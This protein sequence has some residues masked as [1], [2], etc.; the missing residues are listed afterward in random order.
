M[1]KIRRCQHSEQN[2]VNKSASGVERQR[3]VEQHLVESESQNQGKPDTSLLATSLMKKSAQSSSDTVAGSSLS[4]SDMQQG[5]HELSSQPVVPSWVDI[6]DSSNQK[7]TMISQYQYIAPA[8]QEISVESKRIVDQILEGIL[9]DEIDQVREALSDRHFSEEIFLIGLQRFK[10]IEFSL[11][12]QAV[13]RERFEIL[14][15][16]LCSSYCTEDVLSHQMNKRY[17]TSTLLSYAIE[18]NQ[19]KACELIMNAPCFRAHHYL[20]TKPLLRLKLGHSV[21]DEILHIMNTLLS[22][23]NADAVKQAL[24]MKN[25]EGM[26]PLISVLVE[27]TDFARVDQEGK[28]RFENLLNLFYKMCGLSEHPENFLTA[29]DDSQTFVLGYAVNTGLLEV[30]EALFQLDEFNETLLYIPDHQNKNIF[31]HA[32]CSELIGK[33]LLSIP[34]IE[35]RVFFEV[36]SDYGYTPLHVAVSL[37]EEGLV[38]L[39]LKPGAVENFPEAAIYVPD[40]KGRSIL[41]TAIQT[42]SLTMVELLL[43]SPY[44]DQLLLLKDEDERTPIDYLKYLMTHQEGAFSEDSRVR[45]LSMIARLEKELAKLEKELADAQLAI[46][47]KLEKDSSYQ[48]NPRLKS[49]ESQQRS[50]TSCLA[51]RKSRLAKWEQSKKKSTETMEKIYD[52]LLKFSNI[53][54]DNNAKEE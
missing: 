2:A 53:S 14:D 45:Q 17:D 16:L 27:L 15:L 41:H 23:R 51:N 39:Y 28:R 46:N 31:F 30:M 37:K 35:S 25:E 52:L 4:M 50:S 42:E 12:E 38:K 26:T 20:E 3:Q 44:K 13:R 34:S 8:G 43:S 21:S 47:Q 18:L 5:I 19:A 10:G 36:S 6:S 49:L 29:Q 7:G 24:E 54:E 22:Y 32:M 48:E 40:R 33:R 9:N 1:P 11:L